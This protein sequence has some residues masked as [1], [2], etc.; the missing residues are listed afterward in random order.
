MSNPIQHWNIN[1][2]TILI[3]FAGSLLSIFLWFLLAY[4]QFQFISLPVERKEALKIAKQFLEEHR[5]ID[6]SSYIN[7]VAFSIG[8]STDLYLQMAIGHDKEVE[9]LEKEHFDLFVWSVR[10]FQELRSE[11]YSVT[12]SAATGE[13]IGYSYAI[14][15]MVARPDYGMA[16]ARRTAIDFLQKRF[17]FDPDN[18]LVHSELTSNQ[19]RRSDY[20]FTWEKK[21]I[22]IPWS[23]KP[24]TGGAQLLIGASVSG[25]EI[26]S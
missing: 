8:Q 7:A 10:F 13:V 11:G 15:T 23:S 4:P 14:D 9:F 3:L 12:V 17:G 5:Q 25:N 22:F 6:S 2:K 26:L 21:N 1:R 18:Y 20:H 24:D 19:E 16:Q